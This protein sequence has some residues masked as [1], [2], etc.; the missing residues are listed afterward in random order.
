MLIWGTKKNT[1]EVVNS[2]IV[3]NTRAGVHVVGEDSK[4]KTRKT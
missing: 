3:F 1:I 2:K 4:I